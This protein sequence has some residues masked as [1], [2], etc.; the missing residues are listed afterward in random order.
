MKKD[1]KM[2]SG[3]TVEVEVT[4]QIGEILVTFKRK[5]D[6]ASRKARWRN[7]ASVEGMFEET[8]WEP[9][10]K[11]AYIEANYDEREEKETLA[12]AVAGLS[13]KQRRLVRLRYY[14]NKTDAEIARELGVSRPAV[15]QQFGTIHKALKKYFE[16]E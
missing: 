4:A 1:Y 14:E 12:A 10:D 13:G 6:N 16:K 11:T 7:E 9:T 3:K 8:G 5:D 2:A 15:T